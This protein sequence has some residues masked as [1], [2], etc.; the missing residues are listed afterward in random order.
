MSQRS[1]IIL[2]NVI[3]YIVI[4]FA[5]LLVIFILF[6][7]PFALI[8]PALL[9]TLFVLVG[10]VLYSFSSFRFMQK[11][12]N[13]NFVFRAGFSDFIKVNAF[14]TLFFLFQSFYGLSELLMNREILNKL[15]DVFINENKAIISSL[16]PSEQKIFRYQVLISARVSIWVFFSYNLFLLFHVIS[17]FLLIQKNARLFKKS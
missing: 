15:L 7:L 6:I 3:S 16:P 12:L 2:Y 8:E 4:V 9:F 13:K 5:V 17:S 1:W 11:G 10:V 14:V